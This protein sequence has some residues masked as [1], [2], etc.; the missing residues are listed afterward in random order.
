ML[1]QFGCRFRSNNVFVQRTGILEAGQDTRQGIVSDLS[2]SLLGPSIY[3][4]TFQS[5]ILWNADECLQHFDVR[6]Q[7]SL[8]RVRP[9]T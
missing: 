1:Q 8:E 5:N 6:F 2:H 4:S 3:N 9:Q 7:A